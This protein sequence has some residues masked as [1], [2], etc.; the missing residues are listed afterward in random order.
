MIHVHPTKK[1]AKQIY[2]TKSTN[3]NRN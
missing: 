1:K 3:V 2:K